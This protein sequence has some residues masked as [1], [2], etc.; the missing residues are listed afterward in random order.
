MKKKTGGRMKKIGT[1]FMSTLLIL[2]GIFGGTAI[3]AATLNTLHNKEEQHTIYTRLSTDITEMS[4]SLFSLEEAE[5]PNTLEDMENA[6]VVSGSGVTTGGSIGD[7]NK[8]DASFQTDTPACTATPK[9]TGIPAMATQTP[10]E[11]GQASFGPVETTEPEIAQTTEC[12][13]VTIAPNST[14]VPIATQAPVTTVTREPEKT[15]IPIT[16]ATPMVSITPGVTI[17]TGTAVVTEVPADITVSTNTAKPSTTTRPSPDN[18]SVE[19]VIYCSIHYQLNGGTNAAGNPTKVYASGASYRLKDPKKK[20][21]TFQGWY[22]E[23]TFKHRVYY[24]EPD[25]A[26][27]VTYYAKWKIVTVQKVKITSAKRLK[28]GKIRVKVGNNSGADGYEY[29]YSLTPTMAKKLL[30]RSVK[31]PK[32]LTKLKKN[33]RYYIKVRCYKYDSWGRKIYGSYSKVAKCK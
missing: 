27:S 24:V 28:N 15:M 25:G 18:S 19:E 17:T 32:D 16:T 3:Q 14:K 1:V 23:S 10:M 8:G 6:D 9:A 2:D 11:T 7:G 30:V 12:P 5:E 29:V 26:S 22:L 4:M 13:I 20:G 21:Y 31:N 33:A